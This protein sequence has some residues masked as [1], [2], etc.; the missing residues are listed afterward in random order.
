MTATRKLIQ[1]RAEQQSRDLAAADA[2]KARARQAGAA[3]D[4]ARAAT[5]S[6]KDVV[7]MVQAKLADQIIISKIRTTG[8]RFDTS[9]SAL[10]QVKKSGASDAVLLAVT[11]AQCAK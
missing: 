4:S 2:D 3:A 7:E 9:P 11:Q 5:L 10:I 1:S 6:N 8:C